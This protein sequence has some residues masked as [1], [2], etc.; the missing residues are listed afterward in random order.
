M[1][2]KIKENAVKNY[3][4][5]IMTC[6]FCK[7]KLI[8]RHA[9]SNKTVQF[10]SGKYFR[11][12]NLGY[13]CPKCNDN[14]I[15]FSQTANKLC[16]K[17]Y[18]YSAKIV[19]MIDYYKSKHYSRSNICDILA[20]KSIEISDRN[21]DI[22][23]KKQKELF[24]NDHNRIILENYDSMLK[25]FNQICLSI[26]C[27]TVEDTRYIIMYNYFT[28]LKLVI[29]KVKVDKFESFIN[30]TLSTYINKT[31]KISVIVSIRNLKGGVFIPML[32]LLAPNDCK[33]ISYDKF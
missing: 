10:T 15:Y 23:Y 27:I 14:H 8:Y 7:A 16:F 19:C 21:I 30:N 9:I 5:E 2:S 13:S 33:F 11:V 29:W 18:T 1:S 6:P 24:E 22:I 28:G 26:D 3:H 12:R 20:A 4:P 32:K 31:F 25:E 17:G